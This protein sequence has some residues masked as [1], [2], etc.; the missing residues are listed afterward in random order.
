MKNIYTFSIL[1]LCFGILSLGT[2]SP[3][4]ANDFPCSDQPKEPTQEENTC[5]SEIDFAMDT[6]IAI[7]N[8]ITLPREGVGLEAN[9]LSTNQELGS[10]FILSSMGPYLNPNY[11]ALTPSI[12]YNSTNNQYLVVW[13]GSDDI[14]GEYEIWGQRVNAK[15]GAQIGADFQISFIGTVDDPDNDAEDPAVAY[16]SANNEYLVVWSG[17]HY[18]DG[19]FEIFAR[20]VNAETG[21]LVGSM[22]RVSVMGSGTDPDYDALDPAVTYNSANN[23]YL[24]I[25]EGDDDTAP[26]VNN[27]YEIW[28]K[29]LNAS[30]EWVDADNIRLSE[31]QGSGDADYDAY[32]P[33]IAYNTTYNEYMVVWYGDKDLYNTANEEYEIW[34]QRLNASLGRMGA[35]GFRISDIGPDDDPNY[36]AFDPAITYNSANNQY[37][38]VWEADNLTDNLFDIFGQRLEANGVGIGTNDFY[39]S[40][41]GVGPNGNYNAYNPAATYDRVNNEYFVVWQDDEIGSG[42][43]EIWGQRLNASNGASIDID[44]RLSDMGADGDASFDAQTPAVTYSSVNNNQFLIVWSGDNSTDGEFEIWGQRW[45]NG[46]KIY[47]PLVLK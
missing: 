17:D 31:M 42:E 3:G 29:R 47:L 14:V 36:D 22:V 38:V 44:T 27:E 40:N 1:L 15:N 46:F 6:G 9:P 2:I 45:T 16:N 7:T 24:V 10:D 20:R 32:N 41:P 39:I 34:G 43:V 19:D 33:A 13:S 21:A 11:D 37:L 35:S 12:A 28:G 25:W 4:S 23:Q 26:L 8:T 5:G 18:A 30:A